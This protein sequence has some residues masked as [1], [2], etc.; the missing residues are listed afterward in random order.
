MFTSAFGGDWFRI[1]RA[2]DFYPLAVHVEIFMDKPVLASKRCRVST[3]VKPAHFFKMIELGFAHAYQSPV[4]IGFE[5]LI[6]VS[7]Q[8]FKERSEFTA[9]HRSV[10]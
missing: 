10:H 2:G 6:G 3:L 1:V 7:A 9:C 8:N 4:F 5:P